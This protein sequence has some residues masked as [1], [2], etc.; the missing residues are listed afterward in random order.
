LEGVIIEQAL[1]QEITLI[2]LTQNLIKKIVKFIS[3]YPEETRI[4]YS[5][6]SS[7]LKLMFIDVE[8][9]NIEKLSIEHISHYFLERFSP[10]AFC[11]M[12]VHLFLNNQH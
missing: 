10:L 12:N 6:T 4:N 5:I 7:S 2:L 11:M 1:P 8:K 3:S 9:Y